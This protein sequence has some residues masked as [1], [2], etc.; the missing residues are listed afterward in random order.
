MKILN[1]YGEAYYHCEARII[2]NREGLLQLKNTID[3]ALQSGKATTETD[4][5]DNNGD[6]A[7]FASDGEGYEVKVEMHN[8]DWGCYAPKDSYWNKEES[9]PEYTSLLGY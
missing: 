7:L 2:G 1:I 4:V 6:T 3:K 5:V 8:D 9:N